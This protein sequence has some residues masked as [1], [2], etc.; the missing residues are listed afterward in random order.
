MT[1]EQVKKLVGKWQVI[2]GLE[3]WEIV[4]QIGDPEDDGIAEV[5]ADRSPYE[6]AYIIFN[7]KVVDEWSD[8]EWGDYKPGRDP[9]W[10]VAHEL[11]HVHM[12]QV[13]RVVWSMAKQALGEQ[14]HNIF[15][16]Q[17]GDAR[18]RMIDPLARV[19][20]ELEKA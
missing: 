3:H 13:D 15:A 17:Y 9:N 4:A 12:A 16:E 6:T 14:A 7:R 20:A 1:L 10:V 19:L 18:E 2:L 8:D 11:I 5:Y